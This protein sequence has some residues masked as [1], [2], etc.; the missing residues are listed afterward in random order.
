MHNVSSLILADR[1]A[2][3]KG[4]DAIQKH[5]AKKHAGDSSI[6]QISP[7]LAKHGLCPKLIE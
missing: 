4:M 5:K 2:E 3:T 1:L 7:L 6:S